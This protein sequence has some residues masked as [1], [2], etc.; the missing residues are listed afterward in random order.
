MGIGLLLALPKGGS[1]WD[2]AWITALVVIAL[3]A[4]AAAAEGWLFS[5][6]T[7]IERGTLIA[8]G[9]LLIYPRPWL[10]AIGIA[11]LAGVILMQLV[12]RGQ[13][14]RAVIH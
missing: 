13:R 10:D 1:W 3:V 4:L 7:L 12:R 5:K 9:L 8:A 2:V 6:T 11:L 14:P